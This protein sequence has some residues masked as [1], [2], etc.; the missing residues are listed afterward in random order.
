VTPLCSAH[1]FAEAPSGGAGHR[2]GSG[3]SNPPRPVLISQPDRLGLPR[4]RIESGEADDDPFRAAP[5][6]LMGA[7]LRDEPAAVPIDVGV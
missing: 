7:L 5:P 6:S 4:R 3:R 2:R 1:A